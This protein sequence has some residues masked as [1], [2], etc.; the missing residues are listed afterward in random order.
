MGS[1]AFKPAF[2]IR[3]KDSQP[4]T[5]KCTVLLIHGLERLPATMSVLEWRFRKIGWN[6]VQYTYPCHRISFYDAT[7][8]LRGLLSSMPREQLPDHGIGFSM[9]GAI[10]HEF[11]KLDPILKRSL[12]VGSPLLSSQAASHTLKV[13]YSRSI[14]GPAL[15]ELATQRNFVIPAKGEV[16]AIA[17]YGPVQGSWNPLLHGEND[18]IVRVEEALPSEIPVQAKLLAPHIGLVLSQKP[19][20]L[21]RH[22]LECG[23]FEKW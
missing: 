21:M 14:F 11:L 6:V 8:H 23:T 18:G 20:S 4:I 12:F 17:G 10:L 15:E 13:P 3:P 16:G 5:D 1:L 22:F 7:K 9:G 2:P 19:F